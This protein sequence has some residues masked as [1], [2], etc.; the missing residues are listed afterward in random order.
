MITIS[1]NRMGH[2]HI[3]EGDICVNTGNPLNHVSTDGEES[4]QYLQDQEGINF[5]L[6]E[7]LSEEQQESISRGW[8]VTIDREFPWS[9]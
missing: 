3:W 4:D 1:M 9:D 6:M 8:T 2:L 7:Y 5:F